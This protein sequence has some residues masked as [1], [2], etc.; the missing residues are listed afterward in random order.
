MR[1]R[2]VTNIFRRYPNAV[3]PEILQLL[4]ICLT[5]NNSHVDDTYHLQTEQPWTKDMHHLM[6]TPI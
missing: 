1:L 3:R 2:G 6:L 4:E 5:D